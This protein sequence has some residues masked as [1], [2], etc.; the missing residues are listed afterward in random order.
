MTKET[1]TSDFPKGTLVKHFDHYVGARGVSTI[2]YYTV[3][4]DGMESK[5]YYRIGNATKLI[6]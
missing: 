6:F 2:V 5:K 4:I 3:I 1:K